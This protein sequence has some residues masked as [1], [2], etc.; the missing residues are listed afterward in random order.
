MCAK[1]LK[2]AGYESRSSITLRFSGVVKSSPHDLG[3]HGFDSYLLFFFFLP[4]FYYFSLLYFYSFLTQSIVPTLIQIIYFSLHFFS[5]SAMEFPWVL[6]N[7]KIL[8]R[9]DSQFH[10]Q[11]QL[12]QRGHR[13]AV[14]AVPLPTTKY[15]YCSVSKY[16]AVCIFTG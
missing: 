5:N 6:A 4:I 13:S 9:D 16:T 1:G 14:L 2:V 12:H 15:V 8:H 11:V 3:A 7:I 10:P